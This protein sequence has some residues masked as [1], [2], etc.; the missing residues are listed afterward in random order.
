MPDCSLLHPHHRSVSQGDVGGGRL[1]QQ[2]GHLGYLASRSTS[3]SDNISG[4]HCVSE[5]VLGT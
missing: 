5:P 2:S 1:G 4:A 3:A